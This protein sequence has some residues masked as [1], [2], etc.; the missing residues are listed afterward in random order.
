M[1]LVRLMSPH[2]SHDCVGTT[3]HRFQQVTHAEVATT[4]H[5]F[6]TMMVVSPGVAAT[7][8]TNLIHMLQGPPVPDKR[9]IIHDGITSRTC[10]NARGKPLVAR[11]VKPPTDPGLPPLQARDGEGGED[12][13][14]WHSF[15]CPMLSEGSDNPPSAFGFFI[16]SGRRDSGLL[17]LSKA[18]GPYTGLLEHFSRTEAHCS[19]SGTMRM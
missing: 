6:P 19:S 5:N 10:G 14:S 4:T 11:P 7:Q 15:S 3:T 8:S 13:D 9:G 18:V 12:P 1:A 17:P 16:Y 2:L